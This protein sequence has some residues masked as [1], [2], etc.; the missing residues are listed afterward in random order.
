MGKH[1]K[2]H[3]LRKH[4]CRSLGVVNPPHTQ[5]SGKCQMGTQQCQDTVQSAL[6]GVKGVCVM[7]AQLSKLCKESSHSIGTTQADIVYILG[8]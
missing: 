1:T 5:V 3:I 8:R 4:C 7:H 2:L 6:I